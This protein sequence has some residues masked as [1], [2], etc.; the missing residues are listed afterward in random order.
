VSRTCEAVDFC[1][2][3]HEPERPAERP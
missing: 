2:P 3:A 1:R